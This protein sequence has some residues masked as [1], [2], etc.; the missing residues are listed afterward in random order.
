MVFLLMLS[1]TSF[2]QPLDSIPCTVPWIPTAYDVSETH[3][4]VPQSF[5]QNSGQVPQNVVD[6]DTTN[7]ARAHIKATGSATLRVSHTDSIYSSNM[8]VGFYVK[9]RAF[10]D[11]VFSGVT[12]STYLNGVLQE[13]FTGD[14]LLINE[15]PKGVNEPIRIG[16]ITT[17]P[18]NEIEIV[19]DTAGE[20]VYYDV[21]YAIIQGECPPDEGGLPPGLAVSWV[22]FDIKNMGNSVQLMWRTAQE[23]NNQG[24]EIERSLDGRTFRTIGTQLPNQQPSSV[25]LYQF[26]DANPGKGL[27][28][29]R[30]KQNDVDGKINYS[31][32]RT[33]RFGKDLVTISIWPNPASDQLNVQF[34]ESPTAGS[35][36]LFSST[37]AIVLSKDISEIDLSIMLDISKL[38]AGSFTLFIETAQETRT[39]QIVIIK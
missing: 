24:F 7:Y 16:F 17:Q 1:F 38:N 35:I 11:S 4:H 9:S 26:E 3:S 8:F 5:W 28:Y 27:N 2:G 23:I 21:F 19:F 37:G 39:E 20:R 22:S 29:Y 32:V 34:D 12:I 14:E 36:R 25:N 31:I 18:W 33:M 10:R 6:T 15:I 30:I 13:S